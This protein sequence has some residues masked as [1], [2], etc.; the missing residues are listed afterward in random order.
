LGLTWSYISAQTDQEVK[1]LIVT[2]RRLDEIVVL[3]DAAPDDLAI[4]RQ[5]R[6]VP[7]QKLG[8]ITVMDYDYNHIELKADIGSNAP[9]WLTYADAYDPHWHATVNGHSVQV[10]EADGA[11]KAVLLKDSS[12]LVIFTYEDTPVKIATN[13]LMIGAMIFF[14]LILG[15]LFYQMGSGGIFKA[16]IQS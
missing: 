10:A 1:N 2:T 13:L 11:F 16:A 7:T 12:N 6:P 15:A 3:R 8:S 5:I 14:C 4:A 9:A